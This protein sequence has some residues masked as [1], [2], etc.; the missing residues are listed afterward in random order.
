ML[1]ASLAVDEV[2]ARGREERRRHEQGEA[3]PVLEAERA[4]DRTGKAGRDELDVRQRLVVH[5][6]GCVDLL[7]G[8]LCGVGHRG[9]RWG[10]RRQ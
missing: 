5:D 8:E 10:R 4:R 3:V 7:C 9:R 2:Y 6:V 1:R